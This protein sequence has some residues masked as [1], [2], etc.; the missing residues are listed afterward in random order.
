MTGPSGSGKDYVIDKFGKN[1]EFQA[2]DRISREE[3]GKWM[4]DVKKISSQPKHTRVF[5]TA[6]NLMEVGKTIV[7]MYKPGVKLKLIIVKPEPE[8]Y[9][10]AISGKLKDRNGKED[11]SFSIKWQ[12]RLKWSNEKIEKYIDKW[13]DLHIGKMEESIIGSDTGKVKETKVYIV[14]NKLREGELIT[15]GWHG[16]SHD[17]S[18]HKN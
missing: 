14:E 4:V 15:N 7:G 13:I 6:D 16:N 18:N 2:L 12:E 10:Q 8:L 1:L 17:D 5:G 3:N 11:S 9:R